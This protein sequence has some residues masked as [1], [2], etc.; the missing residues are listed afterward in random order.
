MRKP[1]N[2]SVDFENIHFD[3]LRQFF[4]AFIFH[5]QSYAKF[6]VSF[7]RTTI[8]E[9]FYFIGESNV[10]QTSGWLVIIKYTV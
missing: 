5:Y 2:K 8:T 6:Y 7:I 3:R 10:S 1:S 4:L 9:D